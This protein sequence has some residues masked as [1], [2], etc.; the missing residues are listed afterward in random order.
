M[1][2]N[3]WESG[4]DPDCFEML[5]RGISECQMGLRQWS[6]AIQN[7]PRKHIDLLKKLLHD[8]Y[9]GP[10]TEQSRAEGVYR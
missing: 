2:K 6:S 5:F 3:G 8:R 4:V 7:N 10:Q 1:I 9:T